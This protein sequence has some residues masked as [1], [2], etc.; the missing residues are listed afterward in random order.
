MIF[1][2]LTRG[3]KNLAYKITFLV[4]DEYD[5]TRKE[6]GLK[7]SISGFKEFKGSTIRFS[8]F[9]PQDATFT[10]TGA[11]TFADIGKP[12]FN[13][14]EVI[15][16]KT[17]MVLQM[18]GGI[19]S[20]IFLKGGKNQEITITHMGK[21]AQIE[22]K[23]VPELKEEVIRLDASPKI[24]LFFGLNPENNQPIYTKK[25]DKK[26]S[27]KEE[28]TGSMSEKHEVRAFTGQMT[29]IVSIKPPEP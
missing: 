10:K 11:M 16:K 19:N 8:A 27:F 4:T 20:N 1:R 3:Q 5:P 22:T 25:V 9:P 15:D 7:V 18:I 17:R 26:G 2:R 6:I 21:K 24:P 14:L 28:I 12:G 13:T 23:K 29:K